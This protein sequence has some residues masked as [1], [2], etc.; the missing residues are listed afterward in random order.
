MY[1]PIAKN[2]SF[3]CGKL[4]LSGQSCVVRLVIYLL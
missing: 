3:V 2:D 4:L 1:F